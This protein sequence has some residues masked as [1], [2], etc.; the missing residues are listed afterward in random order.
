MTEVSKEGPGA[1]LPPATSNKKVCIVGTAEHW[2]SAPF[3]DEEWDFWGSS[4][5]LSLVGKDDRWTGW[6]E[7][8]D[9]K[10]L[11]RDENEYF[12]W[13]QKLKCPVYTF[14][15]HPELPD[16][17]PFPREK[18][19]QT[20]GKPFL[21]SS[22]HWLGFW[23]LLRPELTDMALYGLNASMG[24][25]YE[26]QRAGIWHLI[27]L[28]TK[29]RANPINFTAPKSAEFLMVKPVY[30]FDHPIAGRIKNRLLECDNAEQKRKTTLRELEIT[31]AKE[32]TQEMLELEKQLAALKSGAVATMEEL[33]KSYER[34]IVEIESRRDTLNYARQ[35]WAG[36]LQGDE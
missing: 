34:G 2:A 23:H 36:Y 22:L 33:I 24:E 28:G 3:D 5:G 13:L 19:E 14:E 8:H 18:L 17:L 21:R 31:L 4:P 25:E 6:L 12:R 11:W 26:D 20:F 9:L 35:N 29:H 10:N 16:A 1:W 15:Q 30:P 27:L 32:K 7:C